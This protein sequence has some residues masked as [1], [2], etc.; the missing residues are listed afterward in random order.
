MGSTF[1][2]LPEVMGAVGLVL[3]PQLFAAMTEGCRAGAVLEP[4]L[5]M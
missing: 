5:P 4:I 2:S 1:Q 3:I